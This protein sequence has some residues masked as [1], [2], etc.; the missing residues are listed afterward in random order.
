MTIT[1]EKESLGYCNISV[2]LHQCNK[3]YLNIMIFS[4]SLEKKY[5]FL[6][7]GSRASVSVIHQ[8]VALDI[9]MV[10]IDGAGCAVAN[11][12]FSWGE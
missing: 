5:R 4:H 10:E 6:N 3:A 1:C 11:V 12:S 7:E 8:I 9:V 2:L